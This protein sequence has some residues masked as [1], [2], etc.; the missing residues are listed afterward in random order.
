VRSPFIR[1]WLGKS[2]LIGRGSLLGAQCGSIGARPGLPSHA[3]PS[4][5]TK[6]RRAAGNCERSS[7]TAVAPRGGCFWG[8]AG[9]LRSI[10]RGVRSVTAGLLRRGAFHSP[11]YELVSSGLSGPCGIGEH[12][13][14]IHR[15][16]SYGQMLMIFFSGG[17][18]NPTQL[19]RQG[20]DDGT[21]YRS[22][23]FLCPRGNSDASPRLISSSSM[24]LKVYPRKIVHR[25][26]AVQGVFSRL[27][28]IIRDY[29]RSPRRPA[30]HR[31]QTIFPSW[32]ACKNNFPS[33]ITSSGRRCG[34]GS[35]PGP[36]RSVTAVGGGSGQ[37][38]LRSAM[39]PRLA[40]SASNSGIGINCGRVNSASGPP[41]SARRSVVCCAR[42]VP[43]C[44]A[45]PF[46]GRDDG[47]CG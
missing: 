26:C 12:H 16:I 36:G 30:L 44:A 21:Q 29:L 15:K 41:V 23:I 46:A 28:T 1:S 2:R 33:C 18:L 22:A 35:Y 13:V 32:I 10:S 37:R 25:G 39:R 3:I 14:L 45:W 19:N 8:R 4:R 34:A 27:R 24:P 40:G 11:S 43:G 9:G 38:R 5:N 31:L 42:T 20:P 7:E 6:R 17:A 47:K